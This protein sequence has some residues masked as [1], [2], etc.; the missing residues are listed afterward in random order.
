MLVMVTDISTEFNSTI[1]LHKVSYELQN[2]P[3][4]L[5]NTYLKNVNYMMGNKAVQQFTSELLVNI[6]KDYFRTVEEISTPTA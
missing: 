4:Y 6:E 2:K 5:L 1:G 3:A